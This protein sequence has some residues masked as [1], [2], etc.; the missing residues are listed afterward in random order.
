MKKL[1]VFHSKKSFDEF[2]RAHQISCTPVEDIP[3]CL[4]TESP[5]LW[6]QLKYKA[7]EINN[8]EEE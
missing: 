7:T 3:N 5:D 1:Y 4:S 2:Y 6:E 8:S